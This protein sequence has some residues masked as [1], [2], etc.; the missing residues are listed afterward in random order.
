MQL[1]PN[2]LTWHA[3]TSVIFRAQTINR[4]SVR[5]NY[6]KGSVLT[7]Q[8]I[9]TDQLCKLSFYKT[10][11]I[12]QFYLSQ[13][14]LGKSKQTNKQTIVSPYYLRPYFTVH[15]FVSVRFS[16]YVLCFAEKK[17]IQNKLWLL[18]KNKNKISNRFPRKVVCIILSFLVNFFN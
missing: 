15:L 16:N 6:L 5:L 4:C 10:Q 13:C 17:S 8:N 2:N 1:K 12:F 14:L 9:N 11:T 7:T 18:K 3:W